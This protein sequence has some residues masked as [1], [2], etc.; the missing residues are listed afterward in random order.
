MPCGA[1]SAQEPGGHLDRPLRGG[2]PDPLGAALQLDVLEPLEAEGEVRAPLVPGQGVDLV[3]DHRAHPGQ[4]QPAA[5]G[6]Q[7][8]VE[9][10]RGGDEDGRRFLHH[11]GP[12][13]RGGVARADRH[14][15]RGGLEA[16]L[17]GRLG[18]L[19]QRAFQ[20]LLD[21]DGQGFERRNVHNPGPAA[22]VLARW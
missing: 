2:Q 19:G 13:A 5:L 18:D 1:G 14:G 6:R 21:V 8:E 4:G 3:H 20:V 7:V 17:L 15:D 10:L 9:A 22:Q 12:G 16:E 11:G